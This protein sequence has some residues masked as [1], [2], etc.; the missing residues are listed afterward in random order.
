MLIF[1]GLFL[2][3]LMIAIGIFRA[4]KREKAGDEYFY[5]TAI[6]WILAGWASLMICGFLIVLQD[7]NGDLKALFLMSLLFIFGT[8]GSEVADKICVANNLRKKKIKEYNEE[9]KDSWKI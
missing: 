5:F 2:I 7:G 8:I 6:K 9:K 4:A 1:V 3:I